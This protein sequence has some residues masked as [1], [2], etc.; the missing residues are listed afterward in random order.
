MMVLVEPLEMI[1]DVSFII[2]SIPSNSELYYVYLIDAGGLFEG[3]LFGDVS[4]GGPG[5][6][7]PGGGGLR[8]DLEE[9]AAGT[10]RR[11]V[12]SVHDR[13]QDS[14]DDDDPMDYDGGMS[15]SHR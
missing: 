2:F 1:L 7:A 14:D 6:V 8:R 10:P 13:R 11:G 12:A 5:G 15:P 9:A 4:G 3:D